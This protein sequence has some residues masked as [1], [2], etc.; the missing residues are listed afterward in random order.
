[1]TI[2]RTK[3]STVYQACVREM[4][5]R[6]P[7]DWSALA[8]HNAG[9]R[10]ERFDAESYLVTS[11]IRY[12]NALRFMATAGVRNVLDVGGFLGAF[13]L[14]LKRLGYKVAIAEKYGYYGNA[15]DRI[16][17]HLQANGVR[18]IDAD[19]TEHA[20]MREDLKNQFDGLTCMAGA[21]HLSHSPKALMG[22]LHDCL[23][24]GGALV[25]EVPNLAYWP[26]RFAFFV[27][28]ETVHAPIDEVYH[29]AVPFT[30]HHREYTLHDARYV[31]RHSG[32]EISEEL[33]FNY[34]VQRNRP[35]Q[36]L[37]Y[38]PAFL[39]NEWA[40]VFMLGCHKLK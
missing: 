30:G 10:K 1:M 6:M 25:F 18:V 11:E 7:A 3:F 8:K 31:V 33:A 29:S 14:A 36:L 35:L 26:K 40:E 5:V 2:S 12:W 34:T 22:N 24:P 16:A 28:G 4:A 13:P 38:L 32:F 15:M 19:L 37:K 21:E 17:D 27:R 23:L 39:F 9:W 20:G